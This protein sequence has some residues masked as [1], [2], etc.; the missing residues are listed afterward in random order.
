MLQ[1]FCTAAGEA[2]IFGRNLFVER[3]LP[4][5]IL[6]ALGPAEMAEYWC[7]FS[8]RGGTGRVTRRRSGRNPTLAYAGEY[9]V[10]SFSVPL[11]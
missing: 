3:V 6:R 1:G 9:A 11:I 5:P 7:P 4:A 10:A 2:T 8:R